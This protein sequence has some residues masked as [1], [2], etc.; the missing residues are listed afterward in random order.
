MV[1]SKVEKERE[2]RFNY[3]LASYRRLH[4]VIIYLDKGTGLNYVL[5][6]IRFIHKFV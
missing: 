2:A 1:E 5:V 4:I 3:A 6:N